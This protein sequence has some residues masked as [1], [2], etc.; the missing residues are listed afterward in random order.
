MN[1]Q[2]GRRCISELYAGVATGAICITLL[3]QKQSIWLD[4][5]DKEK[6]YD[7]LQE[8][9]NTNV[10]LGLCPSG[11]PKTAYQRTTRDSA[12]MFCAVVVDI[13]VFN[14][15]A[16]AQEALPQTKDEAQE[17][18]RDLEL[19]EPSAITDTGNGLQYF[20]FLDEPILFSDEEAK[21]KAEHLSFGINQLIIAEGHKRCWKF[22]NVGDLARIVRAPDTMNMKGSVPKPT[23]V[24]ELS[25]K[26]YPYDELVSYL[27][28]DKNEIADTIAFACFDKEVSVSDKEAGFQAVYAACAFIRHWVDEAKSLPQPLWYYGLSVTGRCENGREIA[29]KVSAKHPKYTAEETDAKLQQAL[30]VAGPVTCRQLAKLGFDGC[31]SCPLF[32]SKNLKSPISLGFYPVPLAKLLGRYAYNIQTQQ[33]AEVV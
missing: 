14:P 28:E 33:F 8:H 13:D 25:A 18:I 19:P 7:V 31:L 23:K 9:Q 2:I 1:T 27:S 12:S 29:H 4:A 26:R 21:K 32:Y 22:D 20:W 15:E 24:L 16:H 17:F 11:A 3:P 10:Y 6:I 5:S 30:T